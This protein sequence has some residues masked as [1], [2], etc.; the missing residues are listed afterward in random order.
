MRHAQAHALRRA[1]VEVGDLD[2]A[3][4]YSCFPSAVRFA[5]DVLDDLGG[6]PGSS[7]H[8]AP[9]TVTGGL[10]YAGGAGSNYALGSTAAMCD[11]LT[12]G[13]GSSTGLVTGVGMH[14][15]KHQ[16]MVLSTTPGPLGEPAPDFVPERRPI[17]DTYDGEVGIATYTVR[18]GGDGA[19]TE[20]LLV[21]DVDPTI[22][23][24]GYAVAREPELLAALEAEE[25]VGRT[26]R[27]TAGDGTAPNVA[28]SA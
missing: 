23:A 13:D 20:A 10:P 4:L 21:T 18:H 16:A 15:S 14:L 6:G 1:G 27:V 17:V 7:S 12:S 28:T 3:D 19:A 25:W 11:R 5:L 8:L 24:R 2:V 26:V 9:Y 22:G